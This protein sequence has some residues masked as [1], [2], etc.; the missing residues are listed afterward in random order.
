MAR[1]LTIDDAKFMRR[2]IGRSITETGNEFIEAANGQEGLDKI[3][4]ESP[5][6]IILDLVMP[7]MDGFAVLEALQKSGEHP[8]VIVMTADIQASVKTKVLELGAHGFLNKPPND[9]ELQEAIRE[10]L[11]TRKAVSTS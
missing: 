6:L 9:A 11:A 10:A 4:S 7:G 5:D 1:V 2:V 8:P 3:R